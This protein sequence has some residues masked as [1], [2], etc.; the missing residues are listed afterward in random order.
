MKVIYREIAIRDLQSIYNY[1]SH[2]SKKYAKIEVKKIK[3][4]IRSLIIFPLKGKFYETIN[5]REIRSI[6]F[7]NYIIFYEVSGDQISI[8]SIHHHSRSIAPNPI[9][10]NDE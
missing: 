6:V 9:F 5:G 8:L 1:I 2:D 3:D 7:R 4:F 10:K